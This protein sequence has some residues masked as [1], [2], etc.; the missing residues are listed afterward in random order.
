[1]KGLNL[2]NDINSIRACQGKSPIARISLP[3]T[4]PDDPRRCPVASASGATVTVGTD[5]RW[6]DRFILRFDCIAVARAVAVEIAQPHTSDR[7]EV[8]APDA[9]V[10][11]AYAVHHGLIFED[12]DGF[13][14]GWMEPTD[15]DPSVWDLHLMPGQRYP[16]GHAPRI[17]DEP[18][19]PQ[20]VTRS[21]QER[22]KPV[23][24]TTSS[25]TQ[26]GGRRTAVN[27]ICPSRDAV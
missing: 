7:P 20:A 10:S 9:F 2:L 4:L 3:G 22:Q 25:V 18:A 16:K 14:R 23:L 12:P 21:R 27:V 13:L 24:S 1:M 26:A 8:L 15:S 5:P 19:G 11:L 17:A 6:L